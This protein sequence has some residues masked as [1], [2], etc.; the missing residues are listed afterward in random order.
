SATVSCPSCGTEN[1]ATAK[2][3]GECGTGLAGTA[4][5]GDTSAPTATAAAAEPIAERRLVSVLFVDLVGFTSASEQRDA[6]D[7]RDLQSSYFDLARETVER[8][9]GL[10][11]KFIGDAVMAVWGTPTAHE[12]DA[13]RAV[14]TALELVAGVAALDVGSQ[15]QARA[16]VLTAEAAVTIGAE[17]QGMVA[18]DMVNT[19]SRLQSA[20]APGTVLV[21][22]ATHRA[23]SGAIT[24]EEIE[25]LAL[26][27]KEEPVRAWRAVAVVGRRGGQ[28]RAAALEP[29]FVGRD[30]ELRLLKDQF[31]ATAREGK[32]R[33]VTVMGQAG[34][35]KSRL[36]WELE[37]YL[38]GVVET[39]LWHEG[40]SPS[41]GEGISYWA[42]AE[43][44]RGR[45]G[46]AEAEDF[47][48][49][50]AKI[51]EML[52]A[53]PLAP[54]EQRWIEPR[55]TGLL[56][57]DELP[58]ESREELFAAWR[59]FFERLAQQGTVM[60]VL[61]DLQWA[62]QGLLDFVEHLL[63]WARTSP[64]FVVAEARPELLER[65]PG[66]G[67]NVRTATTIHLD[68]LS[69]PDMRLLLTGI[70]PAMP[71]QALLAI[72]ERAEGVPL[73]AVETIRMLIDRG[74]LV[75]DGSQLTLAGDLPP[76][77]VP[78][79][80]HALIAARLDALGPDER[81]VVTDAAVLGL[82]FSVSALQGIGSISAEVLNQHLDAL[83]RREI[84]VLDVDPLSA[85]RGQ[86]RFIQGVVR[87]VA[88]QSMAKRERRAKHLAAARHFESLGE[89]ELAGVLASHYLAAYRA[90]PSGGEADA[91]AAQARVALRAAAERATALHAP[92][93]ALEYL[94]QALE[95]TADPIEQ[96]AL[97][98]RAAAAAGTAGR[99]ELSDEH[100]RKAADLYL[101]SGDR[102]GVL[103]SRTRQAFAKLQ[104]HGDAAA[105]E[106]LRA[107]LADVSDLPG[108]P[109]IT[110]AQSELGRV[111]MLQS[112]PES[113]LWCDR[114]LEHPNA[115][116]PHVL[117]NTLIT[118]GSILTMMGRNIEAEA[119]LRG[120]T[121]LADRLGDPVSMLRARN[122]AAQILAFQKTASLLEMSQEVYEIAQ[123]FGD[124]TWIHQAI[125]TAL[126]AS[127]E[128]GDWE[129]WLAE[130]DAELPDAA[131]F[132]RRWFE[133]ERA[134]RLAF[135]GRIDEANAILQSVVADVDIENS[136]Q[137]MAFMVMIEAELRM[138]EGR[139]IDAFEVS[140]RGWGSNDS[141][142][143]ILQI[144]VLAAAAA[145]DASR[146]A[147]AV[148]V[149][150]NVLIE[151]LPLAHAARQI[152][153][154]LEALLAGRW[155]EARTS[156]RNARRLLEDIG[157]MTLLAQLQL[158]VGHLAADKFPEAAEA[159]RAAEEYFHERGADAYVV[160]FR[161]KAAGPLALEPDRPAVGRELLQQPDRVADGR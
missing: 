51:A 87:E 126:S 68:P 143:Q 21:G 133:T 108:A 42:L 44:V 139:W 43:I 93:G 52:A 116:S 4:S 141:T 125:G 95:V 41:Y 99:L 110:E 35:G 109:E 85:E 19:A 58:A 94:E 129:A 140:R 106:I 120:S 132:Y 77:A 158:R 56:G 59:T 28:G 63:V 66:W 6:E 25:P 74:A 17:G 75:S 31:H 161:T 105:G 38:D 11:E 50:R 23:A 124:R 62:D 135:R 127:L 98:E 8:H 154:A 92:H 78:E 160:T 151:D 14:R 156:Y 117:M 22:E 150:S 46:I 49:A 103:R 130:A 9:G 100:A 134:R 145:G 107:A 57:L 119:I 113:L 79:T 138:A 39:V 155:D 12:D 122:N 67:S 2:F 152:A 83:V 112:S 128:T 159:A 26:K 148:R 16:G 10:I 96:A 13:E 104:A 61:W 37:K 76:L 20:A 30:E 101:A 144:A 47:D 65:R 69:E 80:L 70:A 24:F 118:K 88:Y 121:V 86:Y 147:E 72:I 5:G 114:V 81:A 54:E 90:S 102:L 111:L 149:Q 64:I 55:L 40:R 33:L 29:P 1:P 48:A 91:L 71:E 73:Y 3:C 84:L 82:S 153:A 157:V 97:H 137:A 53:L 7:T 142:R 131:G 146:L 15:L 136:A 89:D 123:R 18:G 60:L 36:A 45:A 115:V 27:G 32:P 34:I